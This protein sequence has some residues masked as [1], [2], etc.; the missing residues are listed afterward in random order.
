MVLLLLTFLTLG[1]VEEITSEKNGGYQDF[2]WYLLGIFLGMKKDSPK[3][4]LDGNDWHLDK[5]WYYCFLAYL[6]TWS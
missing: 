4:L 6:S 3:S 5:E 1:V 2:P